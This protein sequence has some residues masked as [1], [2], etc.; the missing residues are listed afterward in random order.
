MAKREY[1][2]S[3]LEAYRRKKAEQKMRRLLAHKPIHKDE[4]LMTLDDVQRYM[5]DSVNMIADTAEEPSEILSATTILANF[6]AKR[7]ALELREKEIELKA[8]NAEVNPL[9]SDE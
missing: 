1:N 5:D 6:L 8:G 3:G 9:L 2:L 7:K 4:K